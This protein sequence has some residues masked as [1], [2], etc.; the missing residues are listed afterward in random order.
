MCQVNLV[1]STAQLVVCE[2]HLG[3]SQ[4]GL[5]SITS[6]VSLALTACQIGANLKADVACVP[7]SSC[8]DHALVYSCDDK[9]ER[10]TSAHTVLEAELTLWRYPREILHPLAEP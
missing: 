4:L 1:H 8:F 10:L 6:H 5:A 7:P 2:V 3:I 9:R